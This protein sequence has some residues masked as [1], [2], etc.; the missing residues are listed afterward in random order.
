MLLNPLL[1]RQ[2][3]FIVILLKT[4]LLHQ[5][6]LIFIPNEALSA[7]ADSASHNKQTNIPMWGK[8]M[9]FFSSSKA[10]QSFYL[11]CFAAMQHVFVCLT[12]MIL[13]CRF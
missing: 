6:R 13:T 3:L 2:S 7:A 11:C 10:A 1:R 5:L 12:P 4:L 8:K 9:F